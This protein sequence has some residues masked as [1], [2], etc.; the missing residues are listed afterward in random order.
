M[1]KLFDTEKYLKKFQVK[2]KGKPTSPRAE[3]IQQIV[4]EFYTQKDFRKVMGQTGKMT[5]GE[6]TDIFMKARSWKKNPSAL[7]WKLIREKQVK[8][9]AQ[10]DIKQGN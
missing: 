6:I 7:F 3:L 4:T 10:L 1:D 9:R 8:I 5:E 2:N